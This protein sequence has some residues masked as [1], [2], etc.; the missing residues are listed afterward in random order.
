MDFLVCFLII[1]PIVM[2]YDFSVAFLLN[3][4][5]YPEFIFV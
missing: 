2:V 1:F 4:V 5:R 3:E